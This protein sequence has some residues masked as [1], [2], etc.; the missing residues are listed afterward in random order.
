VFQLG[1]DAIVKST[2]DAAMIIV[3]LGLI[4]TAL[5]RAGEDARMA[6]TCLH[7]PRRHNEISDACRGHFQLR[8]FQHR[9]DHGHSFTFSSLAFRL[10]RASSPIAY[11]CLSR[12]FR[13]SH[14]TALCLMS[15]KTVRNIRDSS[16]SGCCDIFMRLLSRTLTIAVR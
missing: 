11:F 6:I 9:H 8:K 13:Y 2:S 4:S 5:N 14:D 16:V 3:I 12:T 15:R 7:G 10:L 1:L